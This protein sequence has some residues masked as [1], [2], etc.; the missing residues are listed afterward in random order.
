MTIEDIENKLKNK[1]AKYENE[2][3]EEF[4]ELIINYIKIFH[5]VYESQKNHIQDLEEKNVLPKEEVALKLI[6]IQRKFKILE[7]RERIL[8][9]Y[10][11]FLNR[12]PKKGLNIDEIQFEM[13]NE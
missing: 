3:D 1:I 2:L 8:L 4:K 10:C 7:N 12:Q 5:A 6:E 13:V 9:D 11:Y